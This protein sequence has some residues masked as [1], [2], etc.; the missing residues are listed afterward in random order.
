MDEDAAEK[1]KQEAER[2]DPN[3][4]VQFE[5]EEEK[6]ETVEEQILKKRIDDKLN[7]TNAS[8]FSELQ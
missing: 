2:N 3:R 8:Q 6:K 7:H 1:Q 5:K 4:K